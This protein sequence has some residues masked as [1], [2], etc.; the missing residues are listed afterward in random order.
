MNSS[1]IRTHDMN[2]WR[3]RTNVANFWRI[4]SNDLNSHLQH[5]TIQK[6]PKFAVQ[7]SATQSVSPATQSTARLFSNSYLRNELPT[8]THCKTTTHKIALQ[9]TATHKN[10][11]CDTPQNAIIRTATHCNTRLF[12]ANSYLRHQL[13]RC[14]KLQQNNKQI[15]TAPHCNT[16]QHTKIC[17]ATHC[18]TRE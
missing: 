2:F 7:H 14:N 1:R 13:S 4:R 6:I 5:T 11:H 16:L 8:A 10:L 18:N 17:T 3:I 9:H 12:F 15:H